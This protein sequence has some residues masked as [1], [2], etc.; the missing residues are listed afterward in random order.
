MLTIYY[1]VVLCTRFITYLFYLFIG[2]LS[3]VILNVTLLV[4]ILCLVFTVQFQLINLIE[5]CFLSVI[6]QHILILS[7][8]SSMRPLFFSTFQ[9]IQGFCQIGTSII[10]CPRYYSIE[11]KLNAG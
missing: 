11:L 10:Y 4:E 5:L 7:N 3:H 8:F 1:F 2:I 6:S 9:K